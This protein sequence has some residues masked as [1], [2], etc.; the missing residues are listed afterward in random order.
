MTVRQLLNSVDSRELSEWRS[1]LTIKS[2]RS[3]YPKQRPEDIKEFFKG[4]ARRKKRANK[5][6]AKKRKKGIEVNANDGR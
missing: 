3:Q 4:L 2:G 5:A 1:F 6:K